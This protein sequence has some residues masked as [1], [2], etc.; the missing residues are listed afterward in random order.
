M[1]ELDWPVGEVLGSGSGFL[2]GGGGA[3]GVSHARIVQ[4]D[5]CAYKCHGTG[6]GDGCVDRVQVVIH[7]HVGDGADAHIPTGDSGLI[8]GAA[9]AAYFA[10]FKAVC[11][12][13]NV[14]RVTT[15]IILAAVAAPT[16]AA[17]LAL[18]VAS[19]A[20]HVLPLPVRH[21]QRL[22]CPSALSGTFEVGECHRNCHRRCSC[23]PR[24]WAHRMDP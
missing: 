4:R 19:W 14:W 22:F 9:A 6:G 12:W 7:G 24:L 2:G 13:S 17:A 18:A 1:S 15:V 10:R 20:E 5:G 16:S 21:S 23:R 8:G 11:T 3:Q